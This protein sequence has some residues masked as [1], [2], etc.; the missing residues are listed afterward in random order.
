MLVADPDAACQERR[1]ALGIAPADRSSGRQSVVVMLSGSP[2]RKEGVRSVRRGALVAVVLGAVLAACARS[3]SSD[4]LAAACDA[5]TQLQQDVDASQALDPA[6]AT[7]EDYRAAWVMV[8]DDF[9]EVKF[10]ARERAESDVNAVEDAIDALAR[11]LN[12]LPSD[13]SRQEAI[14]A[15]ESERQDVADALAKLDDDLDCPE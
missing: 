10:Y 13:A 8:R 6:T 4:D 7:V 15:V 11:E 3:G 9:L 1:P 2:Q 5:R 14:D 12:G